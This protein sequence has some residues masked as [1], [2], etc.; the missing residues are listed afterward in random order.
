[1]TGL[2]FAVF[3]FAVVAITYIINPVAATT[4]G[5]LKVSVAKQFCTF[6]KTAKQAGNAL[7][8]QIP[9]IKTAIE[10]ASKAQLQNE[11]ASLKLPAHRDAALIT[12]AYAAQELSAN[13][14][15]LG[16]WTQTETNTLAQAVFSAGAIDSFLRHLDEHRSKSASDNKNCIGADA[17][18]NYEAYEL[19]TECGDIE[20]SKS[21]A[22]PTDV[23]ATI[24]KAFGGITNP[25][26]SG[27]S[28]GCLLFNDVNTAYSNKADGLQY[29]QGLIKVSTTSGLTAAAPI[30]E[31][32]QTNKLIK[33]IEA[34]WETTQAALQHVTIQA[35]TDL[36]TFKKLLAKA[37]SRAALKTAATE[38]NNWKAD[39]L[40][41]P[42]DSY[43]KKAYGI[44]TDGDEGTY[45]TAL[46]SL[47]ATVRGSPGETTS[48]PIFSMTV[49][50]L[51]EAIAAEIVTIGD[52]YAKI[53]K[54]I[55][56]LRQNQGKEASEDT[57]NKIK[58]KTECNATAECSFN[59]T[60]TD[61]N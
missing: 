61:E 42:I 26:T 45:L 10:N 24:E 32:K 5:A 7:G 28:N 13:L 31:Q 23:K 43:L 3:A 41:G 17:N 25:E 40:P 38:Y 18:G 37:D 58:V 51:Q 2:L 47:E 12:A 11:L 46:K 8:T 27:G 57:C 56:T 22:G 48:K 36:Q 4:K 30:A 49:T 33:S 6:V 50:E 35:P 34:N 16:S 59:K 20:L 52:R 53:T 29:L 60:E 54:E 44:Q 14:Q 55:D 1:M 39:N 21:T 9:K 19:D 15:A